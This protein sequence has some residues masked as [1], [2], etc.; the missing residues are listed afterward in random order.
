MPRAA[1]DKFGRCPFVLV[2]VTERESGPHCLLVRS[3]AN[4]SEARLM[5]AVIAEVGLLPLSD[6]QPSYMRGAVAMGATNSSALCTAFVG[7]CGHRHGGCSYG[8]CHASSGCHIDLLISS[9]NPVRFCHSTCTS[10]QLAEPDWHSPV[11][12]T[13]AGSAGEGQP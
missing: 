13:A 4:A 12:A 6:C 2:R 1:V 3:T 5:A 8:S 9:C 10:A 7:F 11:L